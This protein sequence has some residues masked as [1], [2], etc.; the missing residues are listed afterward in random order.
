M[1]FGSFKTMGFIAKKTCLCIAKRFAAGQI[2]PATDAADHF[3][4]R[5]V[6]ASPPMLMLQNASTQAPQ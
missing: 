6:P 2:N 5:K 3:L 4:I 1:L